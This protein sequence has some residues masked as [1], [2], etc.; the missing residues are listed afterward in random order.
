M[1]CSGGSRSWSPASLCRKENVSQPR[2]K[3][4]EHESGFP[5]HP[6]RVL[7][8]SQANKLCVSQMIGTSPLQELDLSHNAQPRS[9]FPAV[10]SLFGTGREPITAHDPLGTSY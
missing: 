7:V 4:I 5:H 10:A 1:H 6:T 2:S 8:V 3:R 9:G